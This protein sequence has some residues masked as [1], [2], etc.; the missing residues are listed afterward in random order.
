MRHVQYCFRCI[1]IKHS[2]AAKHRGKTKQST[3]IQ[4]FKRGWEDITHAISL[5]THKSKDA[6]ERYHGTTPYIEGFINVLG[7]TKNVDRNGV[8]HTSNL[9][10]CLSKNHEKVFVEV[11]LSEGLSVSGVMDE[12]SASAVWNDEQSTPQ[13]RI[14]CKNCST[15]FP[16]PSGITS[17]RIHC[18]IIGIHTLSTQRI[19][20]VQ[21]N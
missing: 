1:W 18:A 7:K 9:L 5:I 12:V 6:F 10:K 4:Y 11:A 3:T 15:I 14:E 17:C 16:S 8:L 21:E 13:S 2:L 19:R 20:E